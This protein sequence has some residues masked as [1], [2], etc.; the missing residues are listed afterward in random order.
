MYAIVDLAGRQTKVKKGEK[1]Y[2]HRLE[3]KEGEKVSFDKVLLIDDEKKV[4]IGEPYLKGAAITATV[5]SHLKD[6]KVMIFKKKRR[7]GYK[8]LNGHRQYLTQIVIE[9]ILEKGATAT[10]TVKAKPAPE[11]K[12]ETKAAPK[13]ATTKT[14]A[15]KKTATTTAAKKTTAPKK[16]AAPKAA[17]VKKTTTTKAAPKKTT[18]AKTT[19]T[20]KAAPKKTTAKKDDKK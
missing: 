7:K 12:E 8:K 16:A 14:T 18:A 6:D 13:A 2:V 9:S 1:V 19:A 20:K 11:K 17:A 3:N 5:L 4:M 10:K 15:A